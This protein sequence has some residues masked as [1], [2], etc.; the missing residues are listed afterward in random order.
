MRMLRKQDVSTSA[1]S[2]NSI[3]DLYELLLQKDALEQ[4][5]EGHQ[6]VRKSNRSPSLRLRFGRRSDPSVLPISDYLSAQ[7]QENK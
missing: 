6:L 5:L 1:S 4:R 7:E 2:Q 3:R